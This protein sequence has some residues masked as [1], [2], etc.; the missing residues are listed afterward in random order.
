MSNAGKMLRRVRIVGTGSAIP[1]R[2]VTNQDLQ[3]LVD[4][5]DEWIVARTGIR[6][7]HVVS[8]EGPNSPERGRTRSRHV[9]ACG[10]AAG[11]G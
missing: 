7:R 1:P 8:L 9:S 4:T 11:N 3:G 5:D 10:K 2:K 6:A